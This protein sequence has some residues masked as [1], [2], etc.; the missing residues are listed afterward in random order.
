MQPFLIAALIMVCALHSLA[1][2]SHPYSNF[3][4]ATIK[5]VILGAVM[6][7]G[8]SSSLSAEHR[9]LLKNIPSDVRTAM[10]ILNLEPDVVTYASC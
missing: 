9:S 5:V 6:M 4:L 3:V 7:S 8:G 10:K 2:L 1:H